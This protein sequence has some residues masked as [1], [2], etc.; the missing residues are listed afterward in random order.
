MAAVSSV[1]GKTTKGENPNI[2]SWTSKEDSQLFFSLIK[3]N[4]LIVMG[5]KTYEAAKKL[6]KLEKDKLR[7]AL[8]RNPQKYSA[9]AVKGSLEFSNESPLE[10]VKRLSKKGYKKMLLV[11]GGQINTLFLKANLVDE[12]HLTIEPKIFGTGKN[13]I[14]EEGFNKQLKLINVKKLNSQGTLRLEYKVR[15]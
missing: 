4:N 10:L 2:Y 6:I 13:L 9:D 5:A 15:N 11:G 7:I 3:E 12:L 14:S 1:N 8:T